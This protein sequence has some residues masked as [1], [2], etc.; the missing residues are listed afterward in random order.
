MS[1]SPSRHSVRFGSR[2]SNGATATRFRS[3]AGA[4]EG[5]S[6]AHAAATAAT[7]A[8][9]IT[10]RRTGLRRSTF[11]AVRMPVIGA[12]PP[13]GVPSASSRWCSSAALCGRSAGFFS[14]QRITSSASGSG[15]AARRSVIGVTASV[16]C[17]ASIW[18]GL[19][20]VNGGRPVSIS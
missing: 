4:P 11:A 19:I 1:T 2:T 18:C 15:T 16:T 12:M 5:R 6:I 17:A 8:V 3:S 7:A 10:T 14:R 9:M 13:V 20:P